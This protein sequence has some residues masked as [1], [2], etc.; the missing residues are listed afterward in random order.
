ML[1][2]RLKLQLAEN[3]DLLVARREGL[4]GGVI[5]QALSAWVELE[6]E[7]SRLTCEAIADAQSRASTARDFV[8]F[9]MSGML[10]FLLQKNLS[11][12]A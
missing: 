12:V 8:S 10:L 9:S 2:A 1:P 6:E 7:R 4:R 5:K 11:M 3:I